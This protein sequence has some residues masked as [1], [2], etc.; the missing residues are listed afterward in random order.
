[1]KDSN[2]YGNNYFA[3]YF[4]WQGVCREAWL[5]NIFP[6]YC[7]GDN[8][9]LITKRAYT[10]YFNATFPFQKIRC[11]VNVR[12]VKRVSFFLTFCFCDPKNEDHIF[13][14][15][16]QQIALASKDYKLI[17]FPDET[18]RKIEKYEL[19]D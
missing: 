15:G 4:E 9:I 11:L 7:S 16:Y 14:K 18:I 17:R 8:G 12:D 6:E 1:M 13:A 19:I 10:E 2:A 5:Y 3:K